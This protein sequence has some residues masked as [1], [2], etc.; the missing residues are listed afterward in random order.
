MGIEANGKVGRTAAAAVDPSDWLNSALRFA[1]F[2]HPLC[3]SSSLS[4]ADAAFFK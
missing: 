2:L 1:A 4:L 3:P